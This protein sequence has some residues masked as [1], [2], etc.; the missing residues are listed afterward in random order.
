MKATETIETLLSSARQKAADR[1][2]M[3]DRRM[4]RVAWARQ[5][6]ANARAAQERV[7]KAWM[8]MIEALPDDEDGE[9][10]PDPPEQAELDAIWR[11][12][13]AV[14]DHDRWPRHLHWGGV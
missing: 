4:T 2:R 9:N 6:I 11:E 8:R 5:T 14:R 13:A 1:Q 12:I 7:T 10:L 3:H